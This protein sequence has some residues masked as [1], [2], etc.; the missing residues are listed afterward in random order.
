[1]RAPQDRSWCR[2][3]EK[4]FK[5]NNRLVLTEV[6]MT[7][8][9]FCA[10]KVLRDRIRTVL[11]EVNASTGVQFM[12]IPSPPTDENEKYVIF[13]N[14]RGVLRCVDHTTDDFTDQGVQVF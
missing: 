7:I 10:D 11:D 4:Q 8:F 3:L 14:R 13:I 5:S 2:S 9:V 12:E 1:M 6:M